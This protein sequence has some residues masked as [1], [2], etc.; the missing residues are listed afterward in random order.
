MKQV[1]NIFSIDTE[2]WYH[3]YYGQKIHHEHTSRIIKPVEKILKILKNNQ[4]TA[5]FF[6][7]GQVAQKHPELIK[8]IKKQGHEIASHGFDHLFVD[9]IG[10][11]KFE[12]DL[13]KSKQILESIIKT[14]VLGYRAP[15][16]SVNQ[17][18]TPWFW[19][20]LKKHGFEY[21]SSI[22]PFKTFMYGDNTAIQLPHKIN[23]VLE[24]P[25]PVVQIKN[26]RIP[27]SGGFYLRCLPTLTVKLFTKIVNLQGLSTIYYIH[28]RELDPKQ[29][30]LKLSLTKTFIHYYGISQTKTKL[31][32]ILSSFPCQSIKQHYR[33]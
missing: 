33:L 9:K 4:S 23:G 22:F 24:I 10:P 8:E 28:P 2:D 12:T 17:K 26:I 32:K 21:S 19:S 27:F 6:I 18:T 29:P 25:P 5:T 31:K 3:S 30:R 14:K 11:Q 13:T 1:K 15:A 7:V 20:I 16:W